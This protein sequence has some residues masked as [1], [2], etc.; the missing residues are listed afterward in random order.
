MRDSRK[1]LI[2]GNG[3]LA[4]FIKLPLLSNKAVISDT[5]DS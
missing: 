5:S 3:R 4:R 2:Y 1:R